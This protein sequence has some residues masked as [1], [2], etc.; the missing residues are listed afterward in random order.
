MKYSIGLFQNKEKKGTS[1]INT[2]DLSIYIYLSKIEK[3]CRYNLFI[4]VGKNGK[5]GIQKGYI[6]SDNNGFFNNVIIIPKNKLCCDIKYFNEVS[7]VLLVPENNSSEILGFNGEKYEY[8]N[9]LENNSQNE[10]GSN[11]EY[12]K[13][14]N[15]H[16]E[17]WPFSEKIDGMRI[18]KINQNIF[19]SL[20]LC[21]KKV[22]KEYII[23]SF[24]FYDFMILGR[25]SRGDKKIYILG[26]PDKYNECQ[27]IPMANMGAKKFYP[28]DIKKAPQN[29]SLG[30]WFVFF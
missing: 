10:Y 1:E 5:Y 25:C 22:L 19:E 17:Y 15:N 30:F 2:N 24:K 20:N 3:N 26:I 28:V 27:V 9:I 13:I 6:K 8:R 21:I 12:D 11:E 23:N 29:G 7:L 16:S 4:F 14:I 18:V